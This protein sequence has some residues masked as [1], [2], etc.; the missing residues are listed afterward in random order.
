MEK[1]R[2]RAAERWA[3]ERLREEQCPILRNPTKDEI[4]SELF[5]IAAECARFSH[6]FASETTDDEFQKFAGYATRLRRVIDEIKKWNLPLS[7]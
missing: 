4:I 2:M 7:G 1:R 5:F 6:R 3:A